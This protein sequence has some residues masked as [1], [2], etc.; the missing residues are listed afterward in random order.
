VHAIL[1]RTIVFYAASMFLLNLKPLKALFCPKRLE[2]HAIFQE[3]V[4]LNNII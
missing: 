4:V 3:K 1:A 2:H